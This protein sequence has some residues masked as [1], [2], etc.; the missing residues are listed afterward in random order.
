MLIKWAPGRLYSSWIIFCNF[1]NV[2][3]VSKHGKI[4]EN[5]KFQLKIAWKYL[6]DTKVLSCSTAWYFERNNNTRYMH[7]GRNRVSAVFVDGNLT[8]GHLQ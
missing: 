4:A 8:S 6:L 5:T 2:Q 1:L 3:H 7:A